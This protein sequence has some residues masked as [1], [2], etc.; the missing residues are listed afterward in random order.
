MNRS[1]DAAAARVA[2]ARAAAERAAAERRVVA[3]AA[4]LVAAERE[5]AEQAAAVRMAQERV[6]ASERVAAERIAAERQVAEQRAAAQRAAAELAAE[7]EVAKQTEQEAAERAV[8][9]RAAAER[10]AAEKAAAERAAAEEAARAAEKQRQE[11]LSASKFLT[12]GITDMLEAKKNQIALKQ[13]FQQALVDAMPPII[14]QEKSA[15]PLAPVNARTCPAEVTAVSSSSTGVPAGV[16]VADP[17]SCMTG[18]G[19]TQQIESIEPNMQPHVTPE[20][21]TE[22]WRNMSEHVLQQRISSG[23]AGP[24]AAPSRQAGRNILRL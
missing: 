12:Q 21:L 23:V 11:D 16:I 15:E 2:A 17:V 3:Q 9:E 22:D 10:A 6:A 13:Q 8:A 1:V 24:Q 5:A 18:F 14:P 4:D 7:Q 20:S 19:E